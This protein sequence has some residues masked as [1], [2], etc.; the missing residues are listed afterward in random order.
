MAGMTVVAAPTPS[1]VPQMRQNESAEELADPQR[2]HPC[3]DVGDCDAGRWTVGV[4][5]SDDPHWTQNVAV[6]RFGES[7]DVQRLFTFAPSVH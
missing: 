1:A 2:G 7:Q 5:S 3:V 6:S 4:A